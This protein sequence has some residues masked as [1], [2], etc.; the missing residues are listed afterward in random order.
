M[1]TEA[2]LLAKLHKW[3]AGRRSPPSIFE[4]IETGDGELAA[5]FILKGFRAAA[6]EAVV[7]RL[8]GEAAAFAPGPSPTGAGAIFRV[9]NGIG[10][11]WALTESE[12]V[13]LLGLR[14]AGD[15]EAARALPLAELSIEII[16]RI[17]ILLDIFQTINVLLPEPNRADGWIRQPNKAP[18]FGGASALDVM[19]TG[20]ERLRKVRACLSGQL[21]G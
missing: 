6:R 15:L 20:L 8:Q 10:A 7:D 19:L 3:L 2:E 1:A 21:H 4:V 18:L 14:D 17:A 13:A 16:E 11:A 12:R 5:A 9:I